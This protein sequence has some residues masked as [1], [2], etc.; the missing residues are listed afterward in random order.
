MKMKHEKGGAGGHR[1][2][3]SGRQNALCCRQVQFSH[4]IKC[5]HTLG[6]KNPKPKKNFQTQVFT[7][8]G[9]L[10]AKSMFNQFIKLVNK[11]S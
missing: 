3:T 10:R 8:L 9:K 7:F 5:F 6:R 1:E 2:G 4:C 11:V